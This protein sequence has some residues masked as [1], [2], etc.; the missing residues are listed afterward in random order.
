MVQNVTVARTPVIRSF[1]S[2][3]LLAIILLPVVLSALGRSVG[4]RPPTE[5]VGLVATMPG[6]EFPANLPLAALYQQ[7][8]I[9]TPPALTLGHLLTALLGVLWA[10]H[11]WT[12]ITSVAGEVRNRR[13]SRPRG[14]RGV[15]RRSWRVRHG[16]G[17]LRGG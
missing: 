17:G 14:R 6:V 8:A 4:A 16:G 13:R 5:V 1:R 9:A 2:A 7:Q 10:Y 11:G 12:N 3:S 15:R